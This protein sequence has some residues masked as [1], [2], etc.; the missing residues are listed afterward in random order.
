MGA[1][2][3]FCLTWAFW[4]CTQALPLTLAGHGIAKVLTNP[5]ANLAVSECRKPNLA[6]GPFFPSGFAGQR[7]DD[8]ILGP[9]RAPSLARLLRHRHRPRSHGKAL[10]RAGSERVMRRMTETSQSGYS[11]AAEATSR[12]DWS[13]SRHP[14]YRQTRNGI[15]ARA[16]GALARPLPRCGFPTGAYQQALPSTPRDPQ[17]LS[18]PS[19]SMLS[20]LRP[21][22]PLIFFPSETGHSAR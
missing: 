6:R 11:L 7:P 16:E 18:A 13:T 12:L 9:V 1:L 4:D 8:D 14:L 15:P 2:E 21:S 10:G 22:T 5:V 17:S 19:T 3:G 20:I